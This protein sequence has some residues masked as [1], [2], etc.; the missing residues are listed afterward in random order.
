[1]VRK[2]FNPIKRPL[3]NITLILISVLIVIILLEVL[4]RFTRY[5]NI[6]SKNEEFRNYFRSDANKGYDIQ[7]NID[8]FQ[9]NTDEEIYFQIWS[10]EMGCFDEP[11]KGEKDYIL[12]I[13]D[14]FSHGQVPFADK[15][16]SQIEG[17]L[18]YRVLKCG[19]PGY[20]TKQEFLKAKE[21]IKLIETS[22]RLIILGYC[23]NDLEDDYLFPRY[24]VVNGYMVNSKELVNVETGETTLRKDLEDKFGFLSSGFFIKIKNFIKRNSIIGR[25]LVSSIKDKYLDASPHKNLYENVFLSFLD[26]KWID[27]AW[28]EHFKNIKNIESVATINISN[29]LIIIIPTKEQVYPFLFDWKGA[30]LDPERPNKKIINFFNREGFNYIDLLPSFKEFANQKPRK[31]LSPGDDFYWRYDSHWSVKGEHLVALLVAKH[32]LENNMIT[33][34]GKAERL[35][36]IN[37][38][39]QEV[40]EKSF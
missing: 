35:I 11:Y 37:N 20:G 16:G 38:K 19:V 27:N 13:G 21:I 26:F 7:S 28:E 31:L 17:L 39:L 32:I 23:F 36:I 8:K 10:N 3:L 6:V 5:S 15:W 9:S 18:G 33:I 29:L 4:L 40:R 30:G 34:T 1:M 14:S 25:L 2:I 22:P 24:A 12:L